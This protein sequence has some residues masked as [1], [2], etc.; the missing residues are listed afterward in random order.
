MKSFLPYVSIVSRRH[1]LRFLVS[2]LTVCYFSAIAAQAQDVLTHHNDFYRTGVQSDETQLTP[3]NVN[4][5][6]FGKLFS[7][8]V[9]GQVYAQPLWVGAYT[10]ADGKPHNVLFVATAHNSVYA[11]DADGG[12]PHAGYFWRVSLM[13]PDETTVPA[14]DTQVHDIFPEIGI[15]GTPVIDR[16]AGLIYVVSKSKLIS[17]GKATYFQRLH[18]L[19]L[20][21]GRE[22]MDG[23]VTIRAKVTGTGDGASGGTI[24][25]NA[26]TENQRSAL[27]L[28]DG[29]VWIAWASHGDVY[30]YHGYVMGFNAR[31]LQQ[32]TGVFVDTPNGSDGGIWMSGG[33]ISVDPSGNLYLASGNGT[34]DANTKGGVNYADSALKLTPGKGRLDLATSFTP[35]D[36]NTFSAE[37]LDFGTSACTLIDN[38]GGPFPHLLVTTD[39]IG[40][41]YL[42][43][44]DLMGGYHQNT[45]QNIQTFNVGGFHVHSSLA[46]FN[47]MIYLGLDGGPLTAWAFNPGTGLFD[48]TPITAPS[49]SLGCDNCDGAGSTPSI[50]A[51]GTTNA[52]VWVLNDSRYSKAPAVLQAYD[53][54][55][56]A[57][58]YSSTMAPN[59]R[60]QADLAIKFTT[61]TI[62]NGFV[63]VGGESSITVYGLLKNAPAIA[64]TPVISPL[65]GDAAGPVLVTISDSTPGSVIH[66]TLNG[67]TPAG[68]SSVYTKPFIV[69]STAVLQAMASATGAV[70]SSITQAQYVIGTPGSVFSLNTGLAASD[71]YLNGSAKIASNRLRLTDQVI[72]EA[73]SAYYKSKLKITNFTTHFQ[74]QLTNPNSAGFTFVLQNHSAHALGPVG[75]GLGYGP[76]TPGSAPVIPLSAAVKFDLFNNTGEGVDSTG[77]Y[78]DGASPTVPSVDL[79]KT[80]IDLHNGHIFA[81]TLAYNGKNLA[82]TITD[83][84][85]HQS[86]SAVY[87]VTLPK[88][89]EGTTAYAGFTGSTGSETVTADILDWSWSVPKPEVFAAATIPATVSKS[90]PKLEPWSNVEIP[91]GK[92]VLF[93]AAAVGQS[94]TFTVKVVDEATFTL[95]LLADRGPKRGILE[96]AI[97]GKKFGAPADNYA[98]EEGVFDRNLGAVLLTAGKHTFTFT[99]TG[100]NRASAGFEASFGKFTLE[101]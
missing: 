98:A 42:I 43:D 92:G 14:A 57:E 66:Y 82:E 26:L 50:S 85:T 95:N 53:S 38:P 58:L 100:K 60:D 3:E 83:T 28:A 20:V 89:L 25:F 12:N 15:I 72:Y 8:P 67:G 96:L 63:Y 47:S 2:V 52:I 69:S 74:F 71:F 49:S 1:W 31:N 54:N 91:D 79:S 32:S 16:T 40:K 59:G 35:F 86:A 73:G 11:F 4:P 88:T 78:T 68:E 23:P 19:S 7:L 21:N 84:V 6:T 56:D 93:P 55:L 51:N 9:D 76:N 77:F 70:P 87:P 44:R 18:A 94:V 81:A 61:P 41:I 36:Q 48:T 101:P 30:P 33:G 10:M 65:P 17:S 99:V 46:F 37:D 64:A 75:G 62:A 97:D 29:S 80:P 5:A 45:N 22:M 24:T 27:A 39:K 13:G 34:F 90:A